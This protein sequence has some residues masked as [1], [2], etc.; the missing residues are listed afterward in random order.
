MV[1]NVIE[2]GCYI[3]LVNVLYFIVCKLF[4][5][6]RDNLF[7]SIS[8]DKSKKKSNRIGEHENSIAHREATT[9]RLIRT[10]KTKSVNKEL[11]RQITIE[12]EHWVN[13]L[14]RVVSVIK[15]IASRGLP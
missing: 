7:V 2:N 9:K 3:L 1:K 11:H 4:G 14:R 15:F 12:I 13:V 8:F 10:D 5:T 6:L